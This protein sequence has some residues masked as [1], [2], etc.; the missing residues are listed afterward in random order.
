MA[1][2]IDDRE[3]LKEKG[4]TTSDSS[5]SWIDDTDVSNCRISESEKCRLVDLLIE[6]EDVF[7]TNKFDLGRAHRFTHDI[8]TGD[9]QPLAQ[10]PYGIPHSQLNMIDEHIQ[11]MLE[12]GIIQ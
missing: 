11:N 8:D 4:K 7:T 12:K 9:H 5:T 1:E 3:C 2:I 10:R 6:Y